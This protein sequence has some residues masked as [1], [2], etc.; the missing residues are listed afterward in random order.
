LLLI[1]AVV[2]ED[3]QRIDSVVFDV[4]GVLLD[5]DPEYLYRQMIA[6][7]DERRWFLTEVCSAEWNAAQDAGRNWADATSELAAR[8][9]A[10][11]A[12]ITAYDE[13]W[14]EMVAGP[15]E[16]S[17]EVLQDLR[18]A[19]VPTFALTNFSAEKWIVAKNRWDFLNRFDGEVV[20]GVEGVTKPDPEIYR[21]LLD[22]Y[23]LDPSRTFYTDDLASNV[24]AARDLGFVAEVFV[25]AST[26]RRQLI[27]RGVLDS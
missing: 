27:D 18:E 23:G 6:D 7:D 14:E 13:Q 19:A 17:V 4:G 8:F 22:R 25:D 24:E 26:L 2:S 5:W 15:L 3:N 16:E 1:S 20:S 12:L 11:T 9:P 10:H 21:I